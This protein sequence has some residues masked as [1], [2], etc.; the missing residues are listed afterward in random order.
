MSRSYYLH[1]I[2]PQNI[3]TVQTNSDVDICTIYSEDSC[4]MNSKF[5]VQGVCFQESTDKD[6]ENSQTLFGTI[7]FLKWCNF[8]PL[9]FRKLIS[10]VHFMLDRDLVTGMCSCQC[11]RTSNLAMLH[12]FAK[13]A[14]HTWWLVST[15]QLHLLK[16]NTTLRILHSTRSI[17]CSATLSW[18]KSREPICSIYSLTPF[19]AQGT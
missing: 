10:I 7:L 9:Y 1:T 4:N 19:S 8:V 5:S 17:P 11:H 2:C 3:K 15:L 13:V 6:G 12:T 14:V 16:T 18:I